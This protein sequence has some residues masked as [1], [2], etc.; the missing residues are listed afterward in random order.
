MSGGVGGEASR[1]APLSRFLC[2][3]TRGSC[4]DGKAAEWSI[5]VAEFRTAD[6][7]AVAVVLQD[8]I[9]AQPGT[10]RGAALLSLD[11]SSTSA[12]VKP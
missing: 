1:D 6:V 4:Q 11:A 10:I 7:D 9:A 12:A 2:G 5:P 3:A 8:G